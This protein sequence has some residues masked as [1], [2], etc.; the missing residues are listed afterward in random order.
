MAWLDPLRPVLPAVFVLTT[1]A[2]LRGTIATGVHMMLGIV[3]IVALSAIPHGLRSIGV[4]L[5]ATIVALL[6]FRRR[7]TL[8][9]RVAAGSSAIIVAVLAL[10][11]V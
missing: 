11:G 9:L 2:N 6:I 4:W 5:A 8:G 10:L 7:P 1:W 3:S